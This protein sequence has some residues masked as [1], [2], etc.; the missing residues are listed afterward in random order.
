[1]GLGL[2]WNRHS[3]SYIERNGDGEGGERRH[4]GVVAGALGSA[5][6]GKVVR[7]DAGRE[8]VAVVGGAGCWASEGGILV[9]GIGGVAAE[10]RRGFDGESGDVGQ[11]RDVTVAYDGRLGELE[12]GDGING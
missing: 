11:W 9:V 3:R 7:V 5:L 12:R 4:V 10:D 8:G 6:V 1:M 2:F